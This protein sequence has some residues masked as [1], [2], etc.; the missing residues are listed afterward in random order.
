MSLLNTEEVSAVEVLDAHAERIQKIDPTYRLFSETALARA[1]RD[2]QDSDQRRRSRESRGPLDGVPF[3]VKDNFD[4]TGQRT[5]AGSDDAPAAA[6]S[7]AA[8]VSAL[9]AAGAV[10]VGRTVMDELA[11]GMRSWPARN[12]RDP[13]RSPGGSSGGSASA[14]AG[15]AVPFALGSDTGGSVQVPAGLCGVVGFK[16]GHGVLSTEGLTPLSPTLD[17]VGTLTRSV[18]DAQLLATVLVPEQEPRSGRTSFVLGVPEALPAS[19]IAP[20]VSR[21]YKEVLR[22]LREAG[23]ETAPFSTPKPDRYLEIETNIC[24]PEF[25]RAHGARVRAR[26]EAY[27]EITRMWIDAGERFP[28]VDYDFALQLRSQVKE[29]W[30]PALQGADAVITPI[31]P[32]SAPPY[33]AATHTWPDGTTDD[34]DHLLGHFANMANITGFP[35]ITLPAGADESGLAFGLQVIGRPGGEFPL[36]TMARE[37]ETILG[38]HS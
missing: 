2:A 26:P 33:G 34:Y 10:L 16:P 14:V 27:R 22:L 30:L 21:R 32:V 11:Y 3:A 36:L 38:A 4:V 29:Q 5:Y 7:D 19:A 37:L 28:Q 31:A 15:Y 23:L 9:R 24:V 35:S 8:V 17:H 13:E 6:T 18:E 20:G 25:A 1:R 12:A